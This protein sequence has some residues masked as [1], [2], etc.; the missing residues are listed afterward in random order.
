MP[1]PE[2]AKNRLDDGQFT[3][4]TRLQGLLVTGKRE[5]PGDKVEM[6]SCS[7]VRAVPKICHQ[8]EARPIAH[9]D[10]ILISS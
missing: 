1:A 7:A 9:V 6:K 10:I 5:N 3:F 8:Y 2:T 4:G